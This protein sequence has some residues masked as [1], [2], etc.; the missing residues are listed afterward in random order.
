MLGELIRT[1]ASTGCL[2]Y[3]RQIT[4]LRWALSECDADV[5]RNLAQG[6]TIRDATIAPLPSGR[7][8]PPRFI[9]LGLYRLFFLLPLL[10]VHL[11]L[12][13][14]GPC[15]LVYFFVQP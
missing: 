14:M 10:G 15:L 13:P 9:D 4:L 8:S 12:L 3:F 7:N 11:G 5:R 2:L 6:H 1:C